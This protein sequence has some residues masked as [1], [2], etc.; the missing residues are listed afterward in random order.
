M[1]GPWEAERLLAEVQERVRFGIDDCAGGRI[2]MQATL[3]DGDI[4]VTFQWPGEAGQLGM[5]FEPSEAPIGPST[6]DVCDSPTE[7]ATEVGWVLM[8]ELQTGLVR[9]G[10]RSVTARGVIELRHRP[11]P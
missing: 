8:E 1:A 10:R 11:G 3:D 2:P 7:W 5:R 4:L 6:G 9:R